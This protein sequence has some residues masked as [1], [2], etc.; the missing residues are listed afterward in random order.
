ME[1]FEQTYGISLNALVE[2]EKMLWDYQPAGDL[3]AEDVATLRRMEEETY[4]HE[5]YDR[6]AELHHLIDSLDDDF[7]YEPES[8]TVASLEDF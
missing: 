4:G 3:S 2:I 6:S 7:P 1:N 8:I 5:D